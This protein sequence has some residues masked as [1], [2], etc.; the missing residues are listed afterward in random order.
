MEVYLNNAAMSWPKPESVYQAGDRFL[1]HLGASTGRG[2]SRRSIE[3][4]KIIENCR[5]ALARLFNVR[6]SSRLVFTKNCSEAL[7][8]AIKGLLRSGDHVVTSSMEHNS[9]WRPLKT[10]EKKRIIS[11]L[12][13][14]LTIFKQF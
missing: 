6:D 3:A 14:T 5:S 11:L 10:L 1:R 9:V 2:V 4:T 7:N 13:L 8:L 12:E